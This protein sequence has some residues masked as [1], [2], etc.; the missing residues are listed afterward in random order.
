M[1][2]IPWERLRH[3]Y[4]KVLFAAK[5]LKKVTKTLKQVNTI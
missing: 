2:A 5:G 3:K 4:E 1:C